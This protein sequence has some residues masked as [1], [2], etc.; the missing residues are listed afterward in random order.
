MAEIFKKLALIGDIWVL[1]ILLGASK[2][3]AKALPYREIV[4]IL[5]LISEPSMGILAALN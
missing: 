5:D 1:W 2:E 3:S 4:R